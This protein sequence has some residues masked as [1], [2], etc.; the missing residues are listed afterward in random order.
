[1]WEL[2]SAAGVVYALKSLIHA[3]DTPL[4]YPV[5]CLVLQMMQFV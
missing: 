1:M 2:I 4:I 3:D 5:I